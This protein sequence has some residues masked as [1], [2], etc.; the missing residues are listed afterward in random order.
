MLMGELDE[1]DDCKVAKDVE[2]F[3]NN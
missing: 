2:G 1:I 3:T